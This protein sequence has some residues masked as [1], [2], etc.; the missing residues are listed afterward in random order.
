MLGDMLG[1]LP[2]IIFWRVLVPTHPVKHSSALV[3][4]I[5]NLPDHILWQVVDI[6]VVSCGVVLHVDAFILMFHLRSLRSRFGLIW[7]GSQ[8]NPVDC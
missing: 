2:C 7:S 5:D 8:G 1:R 4:V 6:L 3:S